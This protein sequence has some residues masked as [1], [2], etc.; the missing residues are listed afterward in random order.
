M[1]KTFVSTIT[2]D[3]NSKHPDSQNAHGLTYADTY[4]MDT[5][6]FEDTYAM[7]EYIAEDLSLVAGGGYST[8]T[9][10]NVTIKIEE[11]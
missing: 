5:N 11:Q 6:Y 7:R 4:R 8:N 3:T 1:I 2:F 10:E 9:I